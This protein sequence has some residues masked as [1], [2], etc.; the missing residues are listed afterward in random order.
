MEGN[1]ATPLARS[2]KQ[3]SN[4]SAAACSTSGS[5]SSVSNG[6]ASASP[7][8]AAAPPPRTKCDPFEQGGHPLSTEVVLHH[9]RTS[10]EGGWEYDADRRCL[11]RVFDFRRE[12]NAAAST[13]QAQRDLQAMMSFVAS[14]GNMALHA[15]GPGLH[16]FHTVSLSVH[17]R[18]VQVVLRTP[19]LRG[20]SW[21][22]FSLATKAEGAWFRLK[23]ERDERMEREQREERRRMQATP[24]A[25]STPSSPSSPSSSRS[26]RPPV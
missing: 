11:S 15:P 22:D 13:D 25:A 1:A 9:L 17:S 3:A 8:S 14:L 24:A 23:V 21:N 5:A 16:S 26:T 18:K 6:A 4:Q 2:N 7:P 19:A 12:F 10:L 20:I